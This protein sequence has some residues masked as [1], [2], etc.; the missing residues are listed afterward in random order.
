MTPDD[1]QLLK[2]AR[3]KMSAAARVSVRARREYAEA[4]NEYARVHKEVTGRD[5]EPVILRAPEWQQP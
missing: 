2:V 3:Q 1:A 5:Y 4:C